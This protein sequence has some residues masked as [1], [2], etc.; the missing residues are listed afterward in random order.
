MAASNKITWISVLKGFN[1]LLVLC[2]NDYL[3][4][5]S[6]GSNHL[7]LSGFKAYYEPWYMAL[8]IFTS[9][10]L[11]QLSRIRKGYSF[12]ILYIDK[13]KR[14]VVPF[15]FF[16]TVFYLA[17]IAMAPFIKTAVPLSL[18][19]YLK[20]FVYYRGYSS[21][22]LWFLPVLFESMLLY[23]LYLW[24]EKNVVRMVVFLLVLVGF[25]CLDLPIFSDYNVFY[26]FYINKY[27]IFFFVGILFCRYELYR[28]LDKVWISALSIVVYSL[29]Y[30]FT[31]LYLVIQLLGIVM[32]VSISM[33][34]SRVLPN[35]F[36]SF[37]D[38]IYQI[39]LMSLFFQCFV[40]IVL[41]KQL[42]YNE[43]LFYIFYLLNILLGI[44]GPVLVSKCVERV[45]NKYIRLC[46]GLK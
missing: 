38:Y 6:T 32:A 24:L 15:V 30:Y 40:E 14:I 27:L 10:F 8:F 23:P 11:L 2:M 17:K 33:T 26:I 19:E 20:S 5:M 41:W 34:V 43:S 42:F 21:E 1:I 44:Y 31:D 9:G 45:P 13:V 22:M 18:T 3:V 29:V 25:Y 12:K 46:F 36:S 4:D 16:V 28:Y 35:L 39:Y 37:R 7:F